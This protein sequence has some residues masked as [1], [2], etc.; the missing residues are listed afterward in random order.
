MLAFVLDSHWAQVEKSSSSTVFAAMG[1]LLDSQHPSSPKPIQSWWGSVYGGDIGAGHSG[2]RWEVSI[3]EVLADLADSNGTE[4]LSD[5]DAS[6]GPG[7]ACH[8][9][10]PIPE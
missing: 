4:V 1:S 9:F 7:E 5:H 2:F 6:A 8:S 10:E 3:D